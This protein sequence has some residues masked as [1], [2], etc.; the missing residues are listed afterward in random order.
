V[1]DRVRDRA[2]QSHGTDGAVLPTGRAHYPGRA[3][4][5]LW[6]SAGDLAV[7][8]ADLSPALRGE[9][10]SLLLGPDLGRAMADGGVPG[11][12]LGVFLLGDDPA[13]GVLTQGWGVGA[14]CQARAYPGGAVAVLV[15]GNPG[16]A[17]HES[18]VGLLARRLAVAAGWA[19]PVA[20]G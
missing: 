7:L 18:G 15:D 10:G 20:A 9:P 1:L 19:E 6:T 13:E 8:L 3:G 14:Q 12:G 2:V 4:S 5:C 17:Q 16:V 11:V